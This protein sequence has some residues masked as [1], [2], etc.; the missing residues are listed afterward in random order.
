M[1][2]EKLGVPVL[3]IGDS[4]SGKSTMFSSLP[5]EKTIIINTERK[6]LPFENAK[7]F[8]NFDVSTNKMLWNV[9]NTI[10]KGGE[11]IDKYE[12]IVLDSFTSMTEII[13]AYSEFAFQGFEQWKNYN[14]LIRDV[15]KMLKSFK[16][17]VFIVGIPETQDI[18]FNNTKQ[19][20]RVKG[21]ELKFGYLEKE[22]SVVLFTNPIYDDESGE[23]EDCELLYK[24]NRKNTA[25]APIG[26]FNKRPK[27]DALSI[28]ESLRKFYGTKP[29]EETTTT[30]TT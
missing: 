23:M 13:E 9:L 8:K 10:S 2:K 27:N 7:E 24:P 11:K 17:Q 25:K 21:K 29:K 26:L 14:A 4:G 12:Y 18:G 19:Y 30:A 22:F 3:I 16:Q 20:A 15:I 6:T 1:S 28:C 5:P